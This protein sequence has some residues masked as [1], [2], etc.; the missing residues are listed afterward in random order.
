MDKKAQT[1][2]E[3]RKTLDSMGNNPAWQLAI[4]EQVKKDIRQE[5]EDR[6]N[7]IHAITQSIV[8]Y[9]RKMTV[10]V[11]HICKNQI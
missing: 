3:I 5:E 7:I 10:G 1:Y 9:D 2:V 6:I 8:D 11:V 4:L